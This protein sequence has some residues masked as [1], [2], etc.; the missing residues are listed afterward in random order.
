M[1]TKVSTFRKTSIMSRSELREETNFFTF[2]FS[3]DWT[4]ITRS[5]VS[6]YSSPELIHFRSFNSRTDVAKIHFRA[7]CSLINLDDTQSR[8]RAKIFVLLHVKGGCTETAEIEIRLIYAQ[9]YPPFKV[10]S[11]IYEI[12]REQNKNYDKDCV[13]K[14]NLISIKAMYQYRDLPVFVYI[15]RMDIQRE[16]VLSWT[17]PVSRRWSSSRRSKACSRKLDSERMVSLR[18]DQYIFVTC[19]ISIGICLFDV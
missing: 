6:H 9:G 7:F 13:Q 11:Q 15:F 18:H 17:M 14:I 19:I 10:L 16:D 2:F 3:K 1:W 5:F 4:S 12:A 8:C